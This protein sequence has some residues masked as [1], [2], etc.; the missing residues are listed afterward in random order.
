MSEPHS[1][2]RL[3]GGDTQGEFLPSPAGEALA[4]AVS[5]AS[6][7]EKSVVIASMGLVNIHDILDNGMGRKRPASTIRQC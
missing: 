2:W 3:R 6:S 7:S 1:P 5:S 4:L